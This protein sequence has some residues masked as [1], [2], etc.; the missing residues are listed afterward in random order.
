MGAAMYTEDIPQFHQDHPRMDN[1][2]PYFQSM[3]KIMKIFFEL[4]YEEKLKII[5]Y[6]KNLFETQKLC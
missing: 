2:N 6:K 1:T 3:E 4:P 5:K